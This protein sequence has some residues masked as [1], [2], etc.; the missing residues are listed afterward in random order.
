MSTAENVARI[1]LSLP[2]M[3]L[4]RFDEVTKKAGFKDRS[5][6]I[7]V[8]MRDFITE[9]E[10]TYKDGGSTTGA[11]LIIYNH[12]TRGI[13]ATLTDIEHH[14]MNIIASSTHIHLD[15]SRCLKIIVVRGQVTEVR[16]LEKRLRNI[17]GIMQ[18]RLS[19]LKTE[20]D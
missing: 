3:L 7:Q 15:I 9:Q 5:K 4:K 2:P 8:S 18:L 6:A 16:A 12:E 13:D 11:L 20:S 14:S 19:L 10:Q 1:S 17:K